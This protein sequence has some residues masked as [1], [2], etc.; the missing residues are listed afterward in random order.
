MRGQDWP[1]DPERGVIWCAWPPSSN[2][3]PIHWRP[4]DHPSFGV[5]VI[6]TGH[7]LGVLGWIGTRHKVSMLTP[8]RILNDH[9]INIHPDADA[10]QVRVAAMN[11]DMAWNARE[12][13]RTVSDIGKLLGYSIIGHLARKCASDVQQ[14]NVYFA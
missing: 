5:N 6:C 4:R 2:N 8:I 11:K 3:L 7:L 13:E 9:D 12:R 10:L 14:S 1:L